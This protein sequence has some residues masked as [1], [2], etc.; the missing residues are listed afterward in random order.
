MLTNSTTNTLL[1]IKLTKIIF[2]SGR[3]K[4][5]IDY[6]KQGNA[7]LYDK[8]KTVRLFQKNVLLPHSDGSGKSGLSSLVC[9]LDPFINIDPRLNL[10]TCR[11]FAHTTWVFALVWFSLVLL[12]RPVSQKQ[13]QGC[14]IRNTCSQM[15]VLTCNFKK[16]EDL[17]LKNVSY[18]VE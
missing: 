4:K 11:F 13:V 1:H 5:Q 3:K 17:R 9:F 10:F 2:S 14:P 15:C 18:I 7:R 8:N 16:M 12:C 6:I